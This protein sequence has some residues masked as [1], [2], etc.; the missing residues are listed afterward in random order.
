[1][2][3]T[4]LYRAVQS[5]DQQRVVVKLLIPGIC[6][7]SWRWP[8]LRIIDLDSASSPGLLHDAAH[9]PPPV[10]QA[11]VRIEVRG[12][13]ERDE[14]VHSVRDTGAG[15]DMAHAGTLFGVF[16]RLHAESEFPGTG[17][18]LAIVK[19]AVQRH[20]SRVWAEAALGKGADFSF[21]LHG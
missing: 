1:V 21:T 8:G 20:G 7:K 10:D 14:V 16:Q 2:L 11:L 3:E 5:T 4:P 6:I 13:A 15:F 18:G 9:E 19:R 17:V 12:S